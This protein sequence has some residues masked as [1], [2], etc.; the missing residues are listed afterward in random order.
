M[1]AKGS[2]VQGIQHKSHSDSIIPQCD[3]DPE[4]SKPVSLHVTPY[5]D[6][7]LKKKGRAVQMIWSGK[8]PDTGTDGQTYPVSPPQLCHIDKSQ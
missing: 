3:L 8:N 1:V 5:R 7:P 4:V 2:A 6:D